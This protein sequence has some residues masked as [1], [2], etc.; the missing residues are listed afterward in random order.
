VLDVLKFTLFLTGTMNGEVLLCGQQV[1]GSL[2]TGIS[3]FVPQQDITFGTLTAKEH[4]W[5]MVYNILAL[6]Y[7]VS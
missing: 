5:F 6:C 7:T 4:L 1:D 2:L 3:G